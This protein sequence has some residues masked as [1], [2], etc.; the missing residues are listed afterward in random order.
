[1]RHRSAA[2][3]L[4]A[5]LCAAC[6][7][8][9]HVDADG[10]S[11]E[12]RFEGRTPALRSVSTIN[13]GTPR[14]T[15]AIVRVP[16]RTRERGR[17]RIT[18]SADSSVAATWTRGALLFDPQ[19]D[20]ALDQLADLGVGEPR[21]IELRVT[22]MPATGARRQDSLHPASKTL[23]IDL[24][25]AVPQAPRSRSAEL[26][27]ALA[28]GLHEVAHAL[29]ARDSRDR[30]DDEY[31]ASLIAACFRIEG[32]QRGDRIA[33][34]TGRS[35]SH[36]DFTRAHSA[37]AA[38]HVQRDLAAAAGKATLDGGDR[39]GIARLRAFCAQRLAQPPR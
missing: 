11:I 36:P 5:L 8:P 31:R 19:I 35:T 34:S 1:M 15:G 2:T 12:R 21:G 14:V 33:F 39:D 7:G 3:F 28:T 30:Y 4:A 32:A 37:A 6:A 24:L 22:L 18:I 27:A 13:A 20:R 26:D 17:Q 38:Q 16:V 25:V 10:W 23:V 29:R 9:A